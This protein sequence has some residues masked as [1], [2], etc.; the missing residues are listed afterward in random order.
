ML[1]AKA[2]EFRRTGGRLRDR[3]LSSTDSLGHLAG[4]PIVTQ[5]STR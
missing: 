3:I 2:V 5:R 1:R 4:I